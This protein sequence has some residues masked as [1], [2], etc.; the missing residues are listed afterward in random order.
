MLNVGSPS[1]ITFGNVVVNAVNNAN[2][3][4][5]LNIQNINSFGNL[6]VCSEGDYE[7][8]YTLFPQYGI[9]INC[10]EGDFIAMDVHEW[11][12]NSETKGS[13]DRVSCVFYLRE[14]MLKTCPRI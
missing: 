7:G 6:V 9:G 10:V 5:Q 8:A 1:S 2:S 3:Y 11:H 4:V 14:K 13:G 12:C